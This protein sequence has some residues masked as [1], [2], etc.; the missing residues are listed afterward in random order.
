MTKQHTPALVDA[1]TEYDEYDDEEY[2]EARHFSAK[3]VIVAF[4]LKGA[5][6]L[7]AL[8][9]TSKGHLLR[10]AVAYCRAEGNE[11]V[12]SALVEYANIKGIVLWSGRGRGVPSEGS[13]R[14]Y[15]A[16]QLG[17][18]EPFIRLPVGALGVVKSQA[19]TVVFL[20]G[21]IEVRAGA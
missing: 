2:V 21:K 1:A 11:A 20:T 5:E 17:K 14:S 16:Q 3:D 6:G 12:A 10:K 4:S 15:R 9:L 7:N 13:T 18:S 19:V 8:D